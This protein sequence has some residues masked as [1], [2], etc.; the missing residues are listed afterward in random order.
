ML[1]QNKLLV[2]AEKREGVDGGPGAML[3]WDL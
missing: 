1:C 2:G 3:K